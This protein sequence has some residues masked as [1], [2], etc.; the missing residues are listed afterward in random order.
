M[1]IAHA[2]IESVIERAAAAA[3]AAR[4]PLA[5]GAVGQLC[6]WLDLVWT[7]NKK[8]DL[9]AAKTEPELAEL[10]VLD[11]AV[12]AHRIDTGRHVDVGSGFG[13][14]GLP[15]AIL[16][17]DLRTT[18]IEPLAKR[19]TFLR[20]VVGTLGLVERVQVVESK[21][22]PVAARGDRFDVATSRATLAPEAWA[23][24]GASLAPEGEVTVLVAKSAV[25][26][27]AGRSIGWSVDYVTAAGA[28]RTAAA[29]VRA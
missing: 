17:A 11:A 27:L 26:E 15:L 25:P 24:L 8:I 13:A 29:L 28:P 7:W 19:A 3:G 12:L 23:E 4:H 18:L 14:P 6:R 9:T 1:T 16:R 5:P 20:T 21:G 2:T 22:E 10:G